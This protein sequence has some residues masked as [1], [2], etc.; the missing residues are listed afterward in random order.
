[1]ANTNVVIAT[2]SQS[3]SMAKA[4]AVAPTV[5]TGVTMSRRMPASMTASGSGGRSSRT[6]ARIEVRSVLSEML[7]FGMERNALGPTW[8]SRNT[9]PATMTAEARRTP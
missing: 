7:V 3:R 9:S 8:I 5:K 6:T 4:I 1:M 2:Y